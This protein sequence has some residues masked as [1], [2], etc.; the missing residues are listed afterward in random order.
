MKKSITSIKQ[1]FTPLAQA[2]GL[3]PVFVI[4]ES[5]TISRLKDKNNVLVV[6]YPR[7][8][9]TGKQDNPTYQAAMSIWV[10]QKAL[11]GNVTDNQED[12]QMEELLQKTETLL[13]SMEDDADNGGCSFFSQIKF[14][15]IEITPEYRTFG[16][17]N[18]WWVEFM[19]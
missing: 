3:T 8:G 14:D 2:N 16:S 17:F 18:G 7:F 19:L 9:R 1:A 10:L 6:A 13:D 11:T 15:T 12:D 4:E 5:S